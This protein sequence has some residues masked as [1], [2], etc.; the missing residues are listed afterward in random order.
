MPGKP[1]AEGYS[2]KNQVR[3]SVS[4]ACDVFLFLCFS[5]PGNQA[6]SPNL[7]RA[8]EISPCATHHQNKKMVGASQAVWVLG[9]VLFW[10][11]QGTKRTPTIHSDFRGVKLCSR[12]PQFLVIRKEITKELVAE[13]SLTP[14]LKVP[15]SWDV[16]HPEKSSPRLGLVAWSQSFVSKARIE[17]VE[18]RVFTHLLSGSGHKN[19]PDCFTTE[20]VF[21]V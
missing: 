8:P 6:C 4:P 3:R 11:F 20:L 21:P 7:T 1:K 13:T 2:R 12:V 17:D 19:R 10:W 9:G 5:P 14:I 16:T 15:E 18:T